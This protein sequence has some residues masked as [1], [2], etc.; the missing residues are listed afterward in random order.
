M[1]QNLPETHNSR[2]FRKILILSL[3][4]SLESRS[5]WNANA[6]EILPAGSRPRLCKIR[7]LSSIS[8]FENESPKKLPSLTSL[9]L[10][11]RSRFIDLSVHSQPWFYVLS[12]LWHGHT[13]HYESLICGTSLYLSSMYFQ[14]CGTSLYLYSMY[15]LICGTS[16]YLYSMYSLC[17]TSL[18]LFLCTL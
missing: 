17:G 3:S 2:D 5:C 7:T 18:Y 10:D 14:I 15:C 4:L 9:G 8:R 6:G 13:S 12:N 16:L 11:S 1:A